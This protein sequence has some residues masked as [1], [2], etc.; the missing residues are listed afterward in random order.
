[1]SLLDGYEEQSTKR[2]SLL[3]GYEETQPKRTSLLDGYQETQPSQT[4]KKPVVRPQVSNNTGMGSNKGYTYPKGGIKNAQ[5]MSPGTFKENIDSLYDIPQVEMPKRGTLT[6][7]DGNPYIVG[8]V[9]V[10]AKATPNNEEKRTYDT[11]FED[12]GGNFFVNAGKDVKDVVSGLGQMVGNVGNFLFARPLMN[13]VKGDKSIPLKDRVFNGEGIQDLKDMWNNAPQTLQAVGE[14]LKANYGQGDLDM[15]NWERM[16]EGKSPINVD[17]V[18][19]AQSLY[20][21]PLN[22]LDLV[23]LGEAG[24]VGQV[25]KLTKG[26]QT[27]KFAKTV[28][29]VSMSPKYSENLLINAG[30]RVA[31]SKPFQSVVNAI[32]NSPMR[33]LTDVGADFLGL[34]PDSRLLGQ[35]GATV[36]QAKLIDQANQTKNIAERN[37]LI[38]ENNEVFKGLSDTEA[39]AFVNSI[40]SGDN[41]IFEGNEKL[42][43]L[44]D[45]FR[46]KVTQNAD[47]YKERGMLSNEAVQELPI[48]T[49]ASI[50][51]DKN[52]D[53]LT[54]AEKLD[55]LK[56]IEK[57]P[58]EQRP[59][60]V[61]MMYDDN[62]RAGDFFA[63]N[64]KRYKP[65]ELK[66]RKVGRGLE[67]NA[68]GGK[69]IYDPAELVN[70]LDAHRV[71]LVNT[72]NM[73]NEVIDNFAKPL[74][75]TK[76]RVMDGYVPFNPDSF[77]NFY[78]KS[79]DLNEATIKKLS[80][81]DN[82][83]SALR[84][85]IEEAI[86]SLDDDIIEALGVSKRTKIYQIPEE[87]AKTLKQGKQAKGIWE[88]MLDMG[89]AGF[90]RKV[91]GLS[92]KWF[93]NNRIG[94]G[95][96]AGL[97]GVNMNDYLKALNLADELLPEALKTKSMYE[98][99]KTIIGRT[100]GGNNSTFG[101][102][103]RLLGGE[104]IDT[105]DLKG[106][107]KAGIV[108]ANSLGVPMKVINTITDKMFAF[109]QFFEDVER[110]AAYLHSV[111][112][113]GKRMLKS[114]GQNI[115]KQDE[116]LKA[117]LKDEN[118]LNA[119][120][121]NVDDT[122]GDYI[123]MTPVERRVIRKIVPFYSWLRTITRYTLSLAETNPFRATMTNKLSMILNEENDKLPEYQQG[124]IPT[125]F[126][127]SRTNKPLRLNY[128]HSIPFSTFGDTVDNP[129]GLVNPLF[130][131]SLEAVLGKRN[132]MNKPFVSP[133]Y[134]N[135]YPN[136]YASLMDENQGE[137]F[138]ELPMGERIK[139]LP[140]GLARTSIPAL[141]WTERVG[142]G[143]LQN[144][145]G[146]QGLKPKDALYD[147]SF[148]G[149]N[150]SDGF[151]KRP[152]GWDN[153][154]QLLRLLLPLQQ[155]GQA[156]KPVKK[157][158]R[159]KNKN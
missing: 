120:M 11:R 9:K 91:L 24:K 47:F 90:K 14:G 156:H 13:A 85:S 108:F 17:V 89:T 159:I 116:L 92:P 63:D 68:R 60:Y 48:N 18:G 104:F 135:V 81:L 83:D 151:S 45:K 2:T 41:A 101:N 73:I 74:D 51:Y 84:S 52:I 157:L 93:I 39:K 88:S 43:N 40:E 102:T 105:S 23:G 110:R 1:M 87:V 15:V 71:K 107:K 158:K 147:T 38:A 3:D 4:V 95:I 99:E 82:I 57:L 124:S 119:V 53:A 34:N 121:K 12:R 31:E 103:M 138:N 79:I 96:M 139:A 111:D 46:E 86:Q 125:N 22:I 136:G 127:S 44:R 6:D 58:A 106:M 59:F 137:Y 30:Q 80:E 8:S 20:A 55:A 61:P 64:T 112:K 153:E 69:R 144:L 114:A 145:L 35:K 29:N 27:S 100:G 146:G 152:K 149:Y 33:E 10:N 5:E 36:R 98:A 16:K 54:D 130:T 109:N 32:D 122:L 76:E 142:V 97:K 131:Q 25:A 150:Y 129:V 123:N 21:H 115:V 65:N 42:S 49:Y 19:L 126:K 94:N 132:F 118:V 134:E 62:L 128:E 78:K 133:N 70:R 37:S 117:T 113:V 155:E 66:H 75:L 77:L 26:G 143:A 28:G 154:E 148:G 72:E 56:D 141:D 67:V 7:S 50:K 140:I